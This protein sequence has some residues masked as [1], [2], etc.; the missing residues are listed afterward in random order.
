MAE[1]ELPNPHELEEVKEKGFTRR[2]AMITAVFAVLLAIASLGG[3]I[4]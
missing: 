3:R 4:I 1:V 2:V